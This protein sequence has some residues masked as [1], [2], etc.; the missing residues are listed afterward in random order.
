MENEDELNPEEEKMVDEK[1]E[2]SEEKGKEMINEEDEK[3]DGIKEIFY[4]KTAENGERYYLVE[5]ED[6]SLEKLKTG[7]VVKMYPLQFSMYLEG[8]IKEK[9]DK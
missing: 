8:K 4:L 9:L 7:K 6:G 3:L 5:K 1:N 2:K